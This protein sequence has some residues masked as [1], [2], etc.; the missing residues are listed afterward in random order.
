MHA[1]RHQAS[2]MRHV[3]EK[4]CA[5]FVRD[6]THAREVDDAGVS[7]AAA[8]DQ[9]GE[10][11]LRQLFQ[12]VVDDRLGL[13]GHAVRDNLVRLAGEIQMMSVSEVAT[14]GQ[15]QTENRVAGLQ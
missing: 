9:L 4:K 13:L 8:N 10:F 6:L 2:K 7:T 11:L 14:M 1:A 5:D 3:D 15:I 12:R